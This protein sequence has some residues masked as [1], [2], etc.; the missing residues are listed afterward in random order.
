MNS[1]VTLATPDNRS[2]IRTDENTT[3]EELLKQNS[4]NYS[5]A[6]IMLDGTPLP[7]DQ[8]KKSLKEL[9]AGA[10]CT[11]SVCVKLQNAQ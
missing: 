4:V 11:I 9:S 3:I 2:T 7:N 5:R 8:L 10:D 6:S 1:N